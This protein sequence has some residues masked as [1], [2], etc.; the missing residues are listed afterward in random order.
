MK[1]LTLLLMLG[2]LI[3]ATLGYAKNH[4][5]SVS[6]CYDE[7]DIE[8]REIKF[9]L[10]EP[11]N[12]RCY[13][14]KVLKYRHKLLNEAGYYIGPKPISKGVKYNDLGNAK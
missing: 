2:M 1:K 10:N 5:T 8:W 11:V 6:G 3:I 9:L 12:A 14:A 4:C 7:L 13:Y